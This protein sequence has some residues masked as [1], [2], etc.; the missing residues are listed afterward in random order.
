MTPMVPFSLSCLR[1]P[2]GIVLRPCNPHRP[3]TSVSDEGN[4]EDCYGDQELL[5]VT[6]EKAALGTYDR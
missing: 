5:A 4:H 6:C 2:Q 3:A 1:R